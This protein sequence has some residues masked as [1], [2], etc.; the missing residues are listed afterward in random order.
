[1]D[2]TETFE[3]KMR[4]VAAFASQFTPGPDEARGLPLDRFSESVELAARRSGQRIRV[5][6]GEAFV[7]REP[8]AVTDLL[9]LG[10][11]SI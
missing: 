11:S 4:A 2:I 7:T 6:F 8:V 10:G 1:M 3:I 5:R 9:S